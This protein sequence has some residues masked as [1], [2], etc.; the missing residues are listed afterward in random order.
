MLMDDGKR[1]WLANDIDVS[2]LLSAKIDLVSR[3]VSKRVNS[4]K[5]DDAGCVDPPD[6]P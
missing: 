2:D 3:P 6:E 4:P 5:N 1:W